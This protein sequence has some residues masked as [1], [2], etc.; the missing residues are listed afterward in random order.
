MT[1]GNII[2]HRKFNHEFVVGDCTQKGGCKG[3]SVGIYNGLEFATDSAI[4]QKATG[5]PFVKHSLAG[6]TGPQE[7][8]PQMKSHETHA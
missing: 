4:Y 3:Y 8:F 7:P 6:D 2:H 5:S 1:G